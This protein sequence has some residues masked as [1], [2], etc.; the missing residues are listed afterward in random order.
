MD[1]HSANGR[2][3]DCNANLLQIYSKNKGMISLK[4]SRIILPWRLDWSWGVIVE[5]IAYVMRSLV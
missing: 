4:Y 1:R 2:R 5:N 3:Y